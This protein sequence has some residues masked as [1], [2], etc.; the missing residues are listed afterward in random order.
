MRRADFLLD[1]HASCAGNPHLPYVE[2]YPY[3]DSLWFGEECHYRTY[4]P[5]MWLAEVSGVPF[6]LQGQI[7]GTNSDQ[8]QGLLFG[9]TCRIYPDPDRCNPR[10]LWA[11][12]DTMAMQR[13]RLVGWWDSA[14]PVGVEDAP[15]LVYSQPPPPLSSGGSSSSSESSAAARSAQLADSGPAVLASVFVTD[16]GR[17]AVAIANWADTDVAVRLRVDVR[18]LRALG[19]NTPATTLRAVDIAGFQPAGSWA[20]GERVTLHAKGSGYNEGFL[21][22]LV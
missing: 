11:A 17:V 3:L 18:A 22:E 13:P 1:L 10:P 21:L 19:A 4:S 2:L 12:L 5:S 15:T 20:V 9:M 16:A 7:L 6:G 8:W 14:C